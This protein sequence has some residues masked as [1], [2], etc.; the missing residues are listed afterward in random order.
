MKKTSFKD[1]DIE[2]ERGVS[3]ILQE[4]KEAKWSFQRGISSQLIRENRDTDS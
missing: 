2:T 3:K 4:L 1:T